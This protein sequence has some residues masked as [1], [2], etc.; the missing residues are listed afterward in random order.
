MQRK[1]A[2]FA[3]RLPEA[4]RRMLPDGEAIRGFRWSEVLQL[5]QTH[6]LFNDYFQPL[7]TLGADLDPISPDAD[8][9]WYG[10]PKPK[11]KPEPPPFAVA[12]QQ[13]NR[14]YYILCCADK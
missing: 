1:L 11:S 3:P 10:R 12:L 14:Y 7:G 6:P 2:A 5:L 9:S 4:F 8:L 13:I